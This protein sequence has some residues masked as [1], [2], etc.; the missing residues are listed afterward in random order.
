[1]E[2]HKHF[3]FLKLLKKIGHAISVISYQLSVISYQ[4]SVSLALTIGIEIRNSCRSIFQ[5][6]QSPELNPIVCPAFRLRS[7]PKERK[8]FWQQLK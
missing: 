2:S 6:R 8:H 5:P 7:I 1:M 3:H 4:L